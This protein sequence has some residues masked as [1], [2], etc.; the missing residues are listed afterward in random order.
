MTSVLAAEHAAIRG[1]DNC[2]GDYAQKNASTLI[3]L[4]E[5]VEGD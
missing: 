3:E 4:L 5:G 2:Y 1:T